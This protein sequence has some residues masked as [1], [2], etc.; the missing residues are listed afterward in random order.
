MSDDQIDTS[1]VTPVK[2]AGFLAELLGS[3]GAL[4]LAGRLGAR[5]IAKPIRLGGR[6]IAARHADVCELLERDL[7]FGIAAVN[8]QKIHEVNGGPFILGMDRSARL[9][10]ERRAL[11]AALAAVDLERLAREA[12]QDIADRLGRIEPGRP[13]DAVGG[14]ARPIAARTAQRLFGV[15]GP[16]LKTF[17]EVTRSIFGHTFLNLNDDE[18]AQQRGIRAGRMMQEWLTAEIARRRAAGETGDDLMGA[19]MRQSELDDDAVRRSLGGMLVGSVD[20]TATCVA[21]ILVVIRRKPDLQYRMRRDLDDLDRLYG[22]CLEALRVWPHN[23]IVLREAT[24][25]TKLGGLDIKSGERVIAFTLAAMQD[26]SVFA[27]PRRLRPDRDPAIYLHFGGGLHPCAGRAVNRFQI[28]SLV[29]GLL[30][31]NIGRIG[32]ITWAGG[33]PHRL[34]VALGGGEA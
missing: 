16:D 11:Y 21:K 33:F 26:P 25:D 32:R 20:T 27:E 31:R 34:E 6:V 30:K 10:R 23:P 2:S 19:L 29:G 8:A 3:P 18:E 4:G 7:D 14:Y 13:V 28:P 12:T 24:N 9:E 17:M 15:T 5:F 22:W 1:I